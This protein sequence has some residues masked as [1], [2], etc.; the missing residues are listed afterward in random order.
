LLLI[1]ISTASRH[2]QDTATQNDC[3]ILE[4]FKD[5]VSTSGVMR[6]RMDVAMAVYGAYTGICREAVVG[7]V[8][9]S[10]LYSHGG[11]EENLPQ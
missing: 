11:T 1:I 3:F 7:Y 9:A 2:L 10:S 4:L 5:T 6:V 8:K